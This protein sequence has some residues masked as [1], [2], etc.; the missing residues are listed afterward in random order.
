VVPG[1]GVEPAH[2]FGYKVLN[3][4]CLPISPPRPIT[5]LLY[6]A[7][8]LVK[9]GLFTR[10][11]DKIAKICYDWPSPY[12]DFGTRRLDATSTEFLLQPTQHKHNFTHFPLTF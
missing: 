6:Q 9:K 7:F 12:G 4:A 11:L 5:Y 8:A 10:N 2:P 3:L 1:T